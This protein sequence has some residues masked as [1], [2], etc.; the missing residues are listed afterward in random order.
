MRSSRSGDL[1]SA[2]LSRRCRLAA[3]WR[4]RRLFLVGARRGSARL[5]RG[6]LKEAHQRR[7]ENASPGADHGAPQGPVGHL[8]CSGSQDAPPA[9]RGAPRG[10]ERGPKGSRGG[11]FR[12]S[13]SGLVWRPRRCSLAQDFFLKSNEISKIG[14]YLKRLKK[15]S[16][17]FYNGRRRSKGPVVS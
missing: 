6:E 16:L 13:G 3:P 1:A 17:G 12:M 5:E 10:L 9:D 11:I 8:R 2:A 7:S 15:F 14:T 4:C